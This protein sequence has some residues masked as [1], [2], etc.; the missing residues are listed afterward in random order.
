MTSEETR[1]L[2]TVIESKESLNISRVAKRSG[3]NYKNTY[4]VIQKLVSK[5]LVDLSPIGKSKECILLRK[6]HPLLFNA[7]SERRTDFLKRHSD[8]KVIHNK[9]RE[10]NFPFIALVFG[11][12]VKGNYS[13]NSDIDI[14][15]ISEENRKQQIAEILD[16]FPLNI[17]LTQISYENFITM[18]KS[19]EFSVVS[20]VIDNYIAL[21]GIED[22]YRLLENA[23]QG[24]N[25]RS[26]KK[27]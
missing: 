26:R 6:V 27:R 24:T 23:Y 1:V 10:L 5:G 12:Y 16:I 22:F 19:R 2:R 15:S 14:L 4:L 20:E 13:K 11:S 8:I 17:H 18:L 21:I 7:E 9:L 3:M 25:Q